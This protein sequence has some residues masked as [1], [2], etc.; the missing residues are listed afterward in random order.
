MLISHADSGCSDKVQLFM[1]SDISSCQEN[2]P[3]ACET[4]GDWNQPEHV[5]V[6]EWVYIS[7]NAIT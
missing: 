5:K 2:V 1:P 3:Y 6:N 7:P 4:P